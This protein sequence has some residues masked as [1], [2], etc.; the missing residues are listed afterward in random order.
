MNTKHSLAII[1]ASAALVLLVGGY[2]DTIE[3]NILRTIIAIIFIH[4]AFVAGAAAEK[5]KDKN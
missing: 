1:I 4:T 5:N 2:S 3:M